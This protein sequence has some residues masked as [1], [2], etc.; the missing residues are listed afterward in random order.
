[1]ARCFSFFSVLLSRAL[2]F[3]WH[4]I[5]FQFFI[6]KVHFK[7]YLQQWLE[8][9]NATLI[10]YLGKDFTNSMW[11]QMLLDLIKKVEMMIEMWSNLKFI[12]YIWHCMEEIVNWMGADLI[13]AIIKMIRVLNVTYMSKFYFSSAPVFIPT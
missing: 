9:L 6:L 5:G 1:M 13:C 10:K 4:S 3:T 8:Y 7:C 12:S 11:N 2:P